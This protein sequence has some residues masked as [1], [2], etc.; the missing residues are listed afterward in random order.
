MPSSQESSL[1]SASQRFGR[2]RRSRHRRLRPQAPWSLQPRSSAR[3]QPTPASTSQAEE[4]R[5]SVSSIAGINISVIHQ[6]PQQHQQHQ[7]IS[8]G[9]PEHSWPSLPSVAGSAGKPQRTQA[10]TS[11]HQRP[12]L[13]EPAAAS[14]P[15]STA[16]AP[17]ASRPAQGRVV[18]GAAPSFKVTAG[19]LQ[20]APVHPF[21]SS[22]SQI[23]ELRSSTISGIRPSNS[24]ASSSAS[25]STSS[26]AQQV[27]RSHCCRH[28][29][30]IAAAAASII[31]L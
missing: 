6:H 1:G 9:R 27:R 15:P 4:L 18:V 21:P 11:P 5:S 25:S 2:G 10:A 23:E 7:R 19:T 3:S 29:R 28:C 26:A 24:A 31:I 22:T 17:V 16:S 12:K 13:Q 8:Q 20:R 30:A 14:A